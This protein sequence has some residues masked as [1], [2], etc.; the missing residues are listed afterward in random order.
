MVIHIEEIGLHLKCRNAKAPLN[1]ERLNHETLNPEY[2]KP[3][4]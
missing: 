2:S 4:A 3:E 1:H